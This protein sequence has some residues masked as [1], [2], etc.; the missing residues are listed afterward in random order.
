MTVLQGLCDNCGWWSARPET[1]GGGGECRRRA[2]KAVVIKSAQ[3]GIRLRDTDR[4]FPVTDATDWCGD[5]EPEE[6]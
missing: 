4:V 3:N 5:W 6:L 2:P 1:A